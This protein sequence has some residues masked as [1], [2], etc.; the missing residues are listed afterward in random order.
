MRVKNRFAH[1]LFGACGLA[2]AAIGGFAGSVH[3]Q[4]PTD[5]AFTY[6]GQ[7]RQGNTPITGNTD[8]IFTL[9]DATSG[10]NQIGPTL[11]LAN[12]NLN[13][14]GLLTTDLDFG[15]GAFNGQGRWLQIAVRNPAGAG[16]Y[17]TLN[18][19]QP[20]LPTPYALYALNG[21]PGPT[22]PVGPVGPQ[23]IQGPAGPMGPA[24]PVG[25]QGLQGE[26]GPVGPAGA[27][28]AQGEQGPA[29]PAG[30]QGA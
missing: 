10:G 2:V 1:R 4:A 3:A 22:G 7:L 13:A 20:I 23:G 12:V 24:G 26:V 8:F 17:T 21:N 6:Q 16:A 11:V 29:G 18:P 14:R 5:I 15:N 19:R 30:P 28:G 25:P 9:W 27:Q